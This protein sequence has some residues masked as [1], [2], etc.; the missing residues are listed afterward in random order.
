MQLTGHLTYYEACHSYTAKRFGLCNCDYFK[1]KYIDNAKRV[2]I[3]IFE[4]IR[5]H[6]GVPIKVNSLFRSQKLNMLIGGSS[7]SKH[8][9]ALAIDIDDTYSKHLG[10]TNA[11]FF[12]W[13]KHNLLFDQLI[14]EFGNDKNP[15]WVHIGIRKNR[16][17]YRKQIL[18]SFYRN[19]IVHYEKY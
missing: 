1:G 5:N 11:D 15:S 7:T 19:G 8:L 13:A 17:K 9:Q 6:F 10:I 4:P 18:K 14:W 12:Y 2:G 3:E 16:D